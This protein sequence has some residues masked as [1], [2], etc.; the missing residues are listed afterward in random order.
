MILFTTNN[1]S[2]AINPALVR[3]VF[4]HKD[5]AKILFDEA[6]HIIVNESFHSVLA[7]LDSI[8]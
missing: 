7:E 5:G 1:G 6:H 3:I 2:V 4:P 8:V